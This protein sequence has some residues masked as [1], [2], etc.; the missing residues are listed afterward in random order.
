[1]RFYLDLYLGRT[2]GGAVVHGT[3]HVWDVRTNWKFAADNFTGDNFHLYTAH[4][5]VVELGMLPPDPMSLSYG[6]LVNAEGGHVLHV[7]PGPP[8]PMF[9]DFGL[10]P[11]LAP[12]FDRNLDPRQRELLRRHA[13]SVGTVF[14]NLSFMQVMTQGDLESPMVPFLCFRVWEPTSP[15]TTR[16]SS[17]LFLEREA[18]ADFARASY[19]SYVRTFGPS[20]IFEQDDMEN[21]EDCTRA[22][23]G[24]IAQRYGLH[25]GMGL[26][27]QPDPGFP[28]PGRA[29]PGSYGERT[30]L[31]WYGEWQRWLT[32]GPAR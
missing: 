19:E 4:G 20:G 10:P 14:P 30:Q 26:H 29:W 9:E 25:H 3:P 17:Y 27:L 21:W 2:D 15:T 22:N 12:H 18:P 13:W 28:G 8:D 32:G 5:S 7:V 31:A 23:S 24:A 11:E 6:H 1:M 16:I